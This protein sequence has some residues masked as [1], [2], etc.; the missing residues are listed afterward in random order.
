MLMTRR[1]FCQVVSGAAL[2]LTG[3]DLSAALQTQ[4]YWL[5]VGTYTQGKSKGIYLYEW[6]TDGKLKSV[7]LAAESPHPS[8]LAVHPS[9][10]YLY[11]VGEVNSLQGKQ[12]GAVRAFALEVATGR[13]TFLNEQASGGG[14][15][16]HLIVD[17]PGRHVLVANYTGGT[18]AVLPIQEGGHLGEASCVIQHQGKSVNAARQ[19]APHPHSVNLDPTGRFAFVADLGLDRVVVYRYEEARGQLVPHEPP[20]AAVAPGAGPRHFAFHP[21]GKFAYVINE[22]ANTVT[23]F[24]WDPNKGTL[25]EI[26]TISTLPRD[27]TGTS[28]TSEIVVHPSGEWLLG[29]NRGH[30]SISLFRVNA[31]SGKLELVSHATKGIRWPRNFNIDPSGRFVLVASERADNIV[32]FELDTK[33]GVL[34]PVS[35]ETNVPTPVCLKFVPIPA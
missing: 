29:S 1:A 35:I 4:R 27:F 25:T 19:E 7:G 18:V 9:Y 23:A 11:A 20:H 22:L 5:Y 32:V 31:S 24:T 6:S 33:Q 15:P 17:R 30:D 14:A 8:F 2:S 28:Y 13:L 16:C 21:S 3:A 10:K 12:T 34:I 26:Q